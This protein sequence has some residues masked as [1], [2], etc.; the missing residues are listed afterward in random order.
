MED[1]HLADNLVQVCHR[2]Y[3]SAKFMAEYEISAATKKQD[4]KLTK[5]LFEIYLSQFFSFESIISL[6][7]VCIQ[8]LVQ[9]TELLL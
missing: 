1:A 5:N 6:F 3:S 9:H 2:L 7:D 8:F 4:S